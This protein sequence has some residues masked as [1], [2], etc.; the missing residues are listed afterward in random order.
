VNVFRAGRLTVALMVSSGV[1]ASAGL[2]SANLASAHGPRAHAASGCGVGSGHGYGYTYLTKLS[3]SRTSCST[4]KSVAKHH[5]HV[6]GWHC[7]TKRLATS[8]VQYESRVSC[9]NGRRS[10][11]WTFSQNT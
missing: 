1:L 2:I 7:S 10:V 9:K 6:H 5:G 3:V 11:V 4:G 8:P